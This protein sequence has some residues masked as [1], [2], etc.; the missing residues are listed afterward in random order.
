MDVNI[1]EEGHHL[2]NNSPYDM[3]DAAW[4]AMQQR[5]KLH[6]LTTVQKASIPATKP[7][8]YWKISTVA[9]SLALIITLGALFFLHKQP[10]ET[11]HEV[12]SNRE[13]HIIKSSG[14]PEKQLDNTIHNLNEAELNLQHQIS[15]NEISE[16]NEYFED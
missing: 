7:F 10:P 16:Q 2:K 15:E 1:E 4:N 9:A 13:I 6:V 5:I 8:N 12:A 3:D 14:N 11:T